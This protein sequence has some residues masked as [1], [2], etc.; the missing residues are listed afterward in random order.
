MDDGAGSLLQ[1]FLRP[2][3]G[4]VA[5]GKTFRRDTSVEDDNVREGIITAI[6]DNENAVVTDLEKDMIK[7]V[8]RFNETKAKDV[9]T[10]RTSAFTID[11]NE[12]IGEVLD[13]IIEE[14]YS[15][16][17][18]YDKDIDNIIGVL[19]IK[20]L[21]AQVRK[22]NLEL[23]NIRGLLR[24]AYL[25]H[26]YKALDELLLEMQRN[27]QPIAVV[28][29]EYGGFSGLLTMEDILEEIVGD[30]A[31]EDDE[32]EEIQE[33][34]KIS[35][36]TYKIDGFTNIQT[37]NEKL[38]LN[39][40]TDVNETMGGLLLEGLG[41]LPDNQGDPTG[42]QIGNVELKAIK[43]NEKRIETLLLRL[44]RDLV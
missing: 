18:I 11:V 38:S 36:T 32:D 40:P 28:I 1:N 26:E 27:R 19:H 41:K 33:I 42:I 22:G 15:R 3:L 34:T 13:R 44:K 37:V 35:E 43:V 7:R 31:D 25:I 2:P 9:M 17:P 21:F 39:L 29:D 6:I 30:I 12:D 5:N 14:R 16:I 23:I 20:D 24:E 10:P 8:L 4:I